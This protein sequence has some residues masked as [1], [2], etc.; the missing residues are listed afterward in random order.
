MK[1]WA[2]IRARARA[3]ARVRVSVGVGVGVGLGPT[4]RAHVIAIGIRVKS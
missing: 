1:G 2:V 4:F 3:R